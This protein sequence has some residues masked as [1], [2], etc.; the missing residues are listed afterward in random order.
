M[1]SRAKPFRYHKDHYDRSQRGEHFSA[2]CSDSLQGAV[3]TSEPQGGANSKLS[4][5]HGEGKP[6]R[7]CSRVEDASGAEDRAHDQSERR[8]W[9]PAGLC[10]HQNEI[11]FRQDRDANDGC[12]HE[13]HLCVHYSIAVSCALEHGTLPDAV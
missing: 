6:Q 4:A 8:A 7:H 12:E 3:R 5:S 10:E 11:P 9:H 1:N 13:A 2:E